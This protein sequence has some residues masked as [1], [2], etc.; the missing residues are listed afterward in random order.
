MCRSW[1]SDRLTARAGS[2]QAR[3]GLGAVAGVEVA[4]AD[5]SWRDLRTRSR[6]RVLGR[7]FGWR[8]VNRLMGMPA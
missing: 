7:S 3:S 4:L 2:P 1:P 6:R 5:R 8:A